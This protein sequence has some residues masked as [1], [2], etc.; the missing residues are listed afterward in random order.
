LKTKSISKLVETEN[1]VMEEMN[2]TVDRRRWHGGGGYDEAV[3]LG[4][5]DE[6]LRIDHQRKW[7]KPRKRRKTLKGKGE[8]EGGEEEGAKEMPPSSHGSLVFVAL[9]RIYLF[10]GERVALKS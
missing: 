1:G 7:I 10:I 8:K 6:S 3:I 9:R 4:E 5:R 2:D